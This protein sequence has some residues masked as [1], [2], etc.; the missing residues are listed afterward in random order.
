MIL[1]FKN[2]ILFVNLCLMVKLCPICSLP[3]YLV[4][5]GLRTIQFLIYYHVSKAKMQSVYIFERTFQIFKTNF[6]RPF[7]KEMRL[8]FRNGSRRPPPIC[9]WE[10]EW[11]N[12]WLSKCIFLAAC[13]LH[14]FG[15][16]LHPINLRKSHSLYSSTWQLWYSKQRAMDQN[17]LSAS[18]GFTH[19]SREKLSRISNVLD[20][21]RLR[22]MQTKGD[23][24]GCQARAQMVG[25]DSRA[26]SKSTQYHRLWTL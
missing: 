19:I 5:T 6:R 20:W 2:N 21:T 10:R 1:H 23:C 7:V 24:Q 22:W 14:L 3:L 8:V 9:C 13:L 16:W 12:V 26:V 25:I 18:R 17:Q 4:A 11:T 15:L